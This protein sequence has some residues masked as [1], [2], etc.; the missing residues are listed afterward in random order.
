MIIACDFDGCLH[1][2]THPVPG[3]RM[4]PPTEGA[5]E[6]LTLM[7]ELGHTIIVFCFWATDPKNIYTITKWMMYYEIPFDEVT[8]IKPNASWFIDNNALRFT[9]DWG[10]ILRQI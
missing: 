3:R 4:G 8:N 9:G 5:K 10:E 7:K 1:D 2:N 6:A